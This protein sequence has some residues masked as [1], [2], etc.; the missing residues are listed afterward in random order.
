[1]K[2]FIP[3]IALLEDAQAM[4]DDNQGSP[5]WIDAWLNGSVNVFSTK[6]LAEAALKNW[7]VGE[8]NSINDGVPEDEIY[9]LEELTLTMEGDK[10]EQFVWRHANCNPEFDS[11]FAVGKI[12]ETE[13]DKE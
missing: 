11:V 1:M 4:T 7:V 12:H 9:K 2:L 3:R 13:L 6:E 10:D 8:I 5:D